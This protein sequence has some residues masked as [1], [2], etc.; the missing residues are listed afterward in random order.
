MSNS[1]LLKEGASASVTNLDSV[2]SAEVEPHR[3]GV[4][5]ETRY[6]YH[7]ARHQHYK[8]AYKR[9]RPYRW[10]SLV[11]GVL[12]FSAVFPLIAVWPSYHDLQDSYE[13]SLAELKILEDQHQQL[14][15]ALLLERRNNF[16][17]NRENQPELRIFVFDTLIATDQSQI[18]SAFFEAN[19]KV[20]K[21]VNVHYQLLAQG[22]IEQNLA[23]VLI[24]QTGKQ[25]F[26]QAIDFANKPP[27]EAESVTVEGTM[28]LDKNM[29]VRYF[30]IIELSQDN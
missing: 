13:G 9:L 11:M 17:L 22:P 18:R 6:Q 3:S 8:K 14:K 27:K 5:L 19:E 29:D 21:H 20:G 1:D 30:R 28:T 7:K 4:S 16:E 15:D 10:I 24:D 2:V 26:Q 25:I 12:C 23:L